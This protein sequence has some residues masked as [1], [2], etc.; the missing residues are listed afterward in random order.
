MTPP[1]ADVA[2]GEDAADEAVAV[3]EE[4]AVVAEG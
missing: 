3:A 1:P 4:G 2:E